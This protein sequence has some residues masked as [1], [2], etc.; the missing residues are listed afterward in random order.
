M[1]QQLFRRFWAFQASS[2]KPF[3]G[4]GSSKHLSTTPSDLGPRHHPKGWGFKRDPPS[5]CRETCFNQPLE[6]PWTKPAIQTKR[7]GYDARPSNP[8]EGYVS[9]PFN[10][11]FR[12]GGPGPKI[13]SGNTQEDTGA[14]GAWASAHGLRNCRKGWLKDGQPPKGL[15]E[16]TVGNRGVPRAEGGA[17]GQVNLPP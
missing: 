14:S 17:G 2:N 10:Q 16:G 12:Y 8:S 7:Q 6:G 5:G 15:V 13:K 1:F 4:S 9:G 11:P 3:R